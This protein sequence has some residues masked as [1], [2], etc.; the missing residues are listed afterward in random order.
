MADTMNK[1]V[2]LSEHLAKSKQS[3]DQF[4][5]NESIE[6]MQALNHSTQ[7]VQEFAKDN[8]L[9]VT[10]SSE[11][12]AAASI[13]GDKGLIG[14]AGK[15]IGISAEGRANMGGSAALQDIYRKA[16]RVAQSKDFQESLKQSSQLS[17]NKSFASH[18]DEGKRLA[19]SISQSWNQANSFRQEASKSFHESQAYQQQ[20]AAIKNS[21]AS[22]N[23]NYN[24]EF[25]DWL[26]AQKADNTGG[27]IGKQGAAYI[28]ANNTELSYGYAQRFLAEKNLLPQEDQDLHKLSP[29][30]LRSSYNQDNRHAF[31]EVNKDNSLDQM[32]MLKQQ[33]KFEGLSEVYDS[34]GLQQAFNEQSTKA[35][36]ELHA[37]K[38]NTHQS[39]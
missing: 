19:D 16:E 6:Q 27:H 23:A 13:G 37:S 21:A 18:D 10:Q 34:N 2:E 35:K 25:V 36:Q 8:N 24:Q 30:N 33:A 32:N 39:R 14:I 1:A 4:N 12:L 7:I 29:Q 31:I 17:H 22:I 28:I 20:A 3:S 11:I 26:S 9:T 38:Q 15:L 5:N